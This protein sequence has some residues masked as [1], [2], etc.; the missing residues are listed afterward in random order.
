MSSEVVTM[1]PEHTMRD[2]AVLMNQHNMHRLPIVDNGRLVGMLTS[3]DVMKDMVKVVRKLA[4]SKDL[5]P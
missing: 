2:A 1:S 3:S 4:P 5:S